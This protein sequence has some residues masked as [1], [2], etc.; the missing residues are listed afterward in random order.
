MGLLLMNPARSPAPRQ[1][2]N[3]VC[4]LRDGLIRVLPQSLAYPFELLFITERGW[5]FFAQVSL[6]LNLSVQVRA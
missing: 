3:R 1:F 6:N 2:P 5:Q 4:P